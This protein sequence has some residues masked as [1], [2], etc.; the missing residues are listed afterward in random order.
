VGAITE[1]IKSSYE[2]VKKV[3]WPTK[4]ESMRLTTYVIG[5]SLAV[6]LFVTV[7]DYLFKQL[8]TVILVR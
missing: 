6:G 4:K 7:F 8:L 1:Y 2:E 5:V 3:A